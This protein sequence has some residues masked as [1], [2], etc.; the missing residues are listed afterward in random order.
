MLKRGRKKSENTIRKE[1]EAEQRRKERIRRKEDKEREK[2]ERRAQKE[3]ERLELETDLRITCG[4]TIGPMAKEKG[5][6]RSC[7][8]NDVVA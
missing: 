3:R 8:K 7:H 1:Q 6:F 4:S 2:Q 5:D